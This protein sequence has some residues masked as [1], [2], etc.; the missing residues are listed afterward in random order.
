[1]IGFGVLV[2]ALEGIVARVIEIKSKV[3]ALV[4]EVGQLC[5]NA[6]KPRA[7]DQQQTISEMGGG[8]PVP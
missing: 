6:V 3:V 2:P 8:C 4:A 7:R 1:M 5:K